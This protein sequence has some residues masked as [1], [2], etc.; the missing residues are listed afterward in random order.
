MYFVQLRIACPAYEAEIQSLLDRHGE[1]PEEDISEAIADLISETFSEP[2]AEDL[3]EDEDKVSD[4][5][6]AELPSDEERI[7]QA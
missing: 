5:E 4:D 2:E 3:A 7:A 6:T 1:V